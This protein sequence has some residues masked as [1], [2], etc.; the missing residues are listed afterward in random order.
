MVGIGEDDVRVVAQGVPDPDHGLFAD[1]PGLSAGDL[2]LGELQEGGLEPAGRETGLGAE[3]PGVVAEDGRRASLG[4]DP[5]H[6]QGE[7]RVGREALEVGIINQGT[8]H[9][10]V[11]AA[12]QRTPRDL[13]P[14]LRSRGAVPVLTHG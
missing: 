11:D 9:A 5:Q 8:E 7:P 13:P 12:H 10:A 6:E 1:D 2:G 3:D 14:Q 4:A